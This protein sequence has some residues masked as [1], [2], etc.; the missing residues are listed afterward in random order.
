MT[1]TT[2]KLTRAA[3][4]SAA[5]AGAIFV[6]VQIKHPAWTVQAFTGSSATQCS[7]PATC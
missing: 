1:I 4:I 5:A 3:G 6:G 2:A 7:P